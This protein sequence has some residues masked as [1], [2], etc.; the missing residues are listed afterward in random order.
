MS[1]TAAKTTSNVNNTV[2]LGTANEGTVQVWVKKFCKGEK[3]LEAEFS[4]WTSE[5][6]N[7]QMRA[8]MILLQTHERL[9]RNSMST[10]LRSFGI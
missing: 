8:K 7:N 2:G 9:L 6:D 4:G 1:H 10:I 5:V 3:S